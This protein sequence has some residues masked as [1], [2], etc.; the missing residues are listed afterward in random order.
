MKSIISFIALA[1]VS[2]S[3]ANETPKDYVNAGEQV[4]FNGN[5]Y[6]LVWSDNPSKN[7]FKQEYLKPGATL[8]D[9][10]REMITVDVLVG[11]ITPEQACEIKTEELKK[12]K[13]SDPVTKFQVFKKDGEYVLDFCICD[14]KKYLEW[15]LYRYIEV[16][17]G[18]KKYL[19][20]IAYSN[21][22]TL[23]KGKPFF[24][25]LNESRNDMILAL[26][27]VVLPN[28]NK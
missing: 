15:N 8:E 20:L 10:H 2:T 17:K 18:A 23:A 21:R 26:D 4:K 14:G 11:N 3:L 28:M 25:N 6:K 13:S 16:K 7:Y 19:V 27:K 24:K 5:S 12:R 1:I 22:G 9:D